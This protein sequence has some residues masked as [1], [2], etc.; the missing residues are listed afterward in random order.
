MLWLVVLVI[1]YR[2]PRYSTLVLCHTPCGIYIKHL[3]S[4]LLLRT[5]GVDIGGNTKQHKGWF[6]TWRSLE[7]LRREGHLPYA[8]NA[9]SC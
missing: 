7:C 8:G 6:P 2:V 3:V 5:L 1:T 4:I 9:S